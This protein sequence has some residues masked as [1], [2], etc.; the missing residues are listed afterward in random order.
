MNWL[1]DV[2][3]SL[4]RR[5][6]ISNDVDVIIVLRILFFSFFFFFFL[7]RDREWCEIWFETWRSERRW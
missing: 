4:L 6:L 7:F 3:I 1:D 5:M 2:I